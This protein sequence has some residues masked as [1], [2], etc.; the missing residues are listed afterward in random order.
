MNAAPDDLRAG[1]AAAL[2]ASRHR[3][4]VLTG[5]LDDDDLVAQHSPLMSP[6]VWDLVHIANYEELWLARAAGALAAYRP[7]LD[8]LYD[9]FRHARAVRAALPILRPAAAREYAAE[10]R[11]RALAA[12]ARA[13]LA[14]SAPLT[15]GGFVHAMVAQHE[16][17]HDETIL[18]THQIREGPAVLTATAWLPPGVPADSSD[19]EVPGG[20]CLVGTSLDPWALDNERPE[21]PVDVA[22]FRIDVHPVT[23]AQFAEFVT[24]GGY[25]EPSWWSREGWTHRLA[26]DLVAPGFWHR[27]GNSFCRR[28]FGRDEPV[29]MNEPVQH[30][31]FHEAAAYANW[32]GR[33]L[34]TEAEWEKACSWDPD[35]QR[36]RRF[37]WGAAAPTPER[38]NL[39]FDGVHALRP[40]QVG[41]YPAGASAYGV[42]QLIGDVWEWTSSPLLG[43]PGFRAHPY[44][45]YSQVFFGPGYRVL[46]GGSWAT[47]PSATRST[48]RNWDFPIRR[49][50]FAGFRTAVSA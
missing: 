49:Q 18:A 46:R 43:Y 32:R 28:R 31:S 23:N 13:D 21:H 17:Q 7:E 8:E 9:A 37:P 11:D 16:H 3:T 48:F 41:A 27:D 24:A 4:Q 35:Q 1:L 2:E 45:E 20:P 36:K 40:A 10:V 6:F 12:L 15:G 30:V 50:I 29:P 44:D 14:P 42:E 22:T 34:P 38:A 39:A 33:R 5:G 47:H 26:A 19:V 25:D